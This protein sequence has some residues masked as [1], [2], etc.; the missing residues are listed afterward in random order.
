MD[1]CQAL[2]EVGDGGQDIA[3]GECFTG[4][5]LGDQIAQKCI[6]QGIPKAPYRKGPTLLKRRTQYETSMTVY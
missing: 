6:Q 1:D 4:R 3:N 2:T 5:M